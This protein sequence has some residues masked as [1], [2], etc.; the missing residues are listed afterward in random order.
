MYQVYGDYGLETECEL[1]SHNSLTF[2]RRWLDGYTR[3]GDMGGYE[4]LYL[5][6]EQGKLYQAVYADNLA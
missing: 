1:Y 3:W 6:D 2:V 4:N 5:V